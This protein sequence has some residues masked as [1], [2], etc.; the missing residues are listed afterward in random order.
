MHTESGIEPGHRA[1]DNVGE[2]CEVIE[3]VHGRGKLA[4]RD[5]I[6]FTTLGAASLGVLKQ[7][8]YVRIILGTPA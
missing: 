5:F 3:I 7:L 2:P 8:S 6:E 1:L 4:G